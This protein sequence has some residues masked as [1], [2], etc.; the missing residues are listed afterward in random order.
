[1]SMVEI[2]DNVTGVVLVKGPL[3]V[4]PRKTEWVKLR[5]ITYIVQRILHEFIPT[6][7]GVESEIRIYVDRM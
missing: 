7:T 1:M 5:D 3:P 4:I 6:R 2:I